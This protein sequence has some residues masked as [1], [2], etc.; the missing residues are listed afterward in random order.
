MLFFKG[1]PHMVHVAE[2]LLVYNILQIYYYYYLDICEPHVV[3]V[4]L[5]HIQIIIVAD[6]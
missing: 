3:L 2:H 5:K 4:Y 6:S 1:G